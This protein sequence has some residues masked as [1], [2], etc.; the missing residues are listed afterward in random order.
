MDVP[1]SLTLS[2]SLSLSLSLPLTV[3]MYLV[4]V[5]LGHGHKAVLF[6]E[7]SELHAIPQ[8]LKPLSVCMYVYEYIF[9]DIVIEY[10]YLFV[11]E[12][13]KKL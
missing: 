9:L 1:L 12:N 2:L 4:A 11:P 3:C 5:A 6:N 10:F 13:K 8:P 7:A